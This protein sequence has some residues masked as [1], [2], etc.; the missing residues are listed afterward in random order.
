MAAEICIA[1]VQIGLQHISGPVAQSAGFHGNR[2]I[3]ID[4]AQPGQLVIGRRLHSING[5]SPG[6]LIKQLL[7]ICRKSVAE[8][9]QHKSILV[10]QICV[11]INQHRLPGRLQIGGPHMA[12]DV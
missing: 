9:Q 5:G 6:L 1:G 3:G 4:L 8:N 7:L 11:A 10:C 2:T 12:P